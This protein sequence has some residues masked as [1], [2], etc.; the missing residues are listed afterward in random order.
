MDDTVKKIQI[1]VSIYFKIF[2]KDPKWESFKSNI[3]PTLLNLNCFFC[4]QKFSCE[5][6][7][8]RHYTTLHLDKLPVGIFNNKEY[9]CNIC[10]IIFNR[11]DKLNEHENNSKRH[12][13]AVLSQQN[14]KG[15]I[16]SLIENNS[17]KRKEQPEDNEVEK[18]ACSMTKRSKTNQF[19]ESNTNVK[20][21]ENLQYDSH[22]ILQQQTIL[23]K[24]NYVAEQNQDIYFLKEIKPKKI[25]QLDDMN[26]EELLKIQVSI[27]DSYN[28]LQK[29]YKL[30]KEHLKK[31]DN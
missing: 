3:I 8:K 30:V 7:L 16:K 17:K 26:R 25:N 4:K 21:V 1:L 15:S 12:K 19:C 27:I 31:F 10:N 22:T 29:Q 6:S 23:I 20:V 24:N 5:F 9:R 14:L 11:Q 13:Q 18:I 2:N 28:K